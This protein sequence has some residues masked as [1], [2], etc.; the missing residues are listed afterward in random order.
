MIESKGEQAAQGEGRW[1]SYVAF[2]EDGR[3][4]IIQ[5]S[6]GH[7][8]EEKRRDRNFDQVLI[9]D[10]VEL[11]IVFL[12]QVR[13]ELDEVRPGTP[14]HVVPLQRVDHLEDGGVVEEIF[15]SDGVFLLHIAPKIILEVNLH[16]FIVFIFDFDASALCL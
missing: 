4:L 10:V 12:G 15:V 3:A 6:V 8:H 11:F 1:E 5:N 13:V 7:E 2:A 14:G 9:L 16:L